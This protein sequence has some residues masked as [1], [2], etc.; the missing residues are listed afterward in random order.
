M[1]RIDIFICFDLKKSNMMAVPALTTT[2]PRFSGT[3]AMTS[4]VSHECGLLTG[5]KRLQDLQN[6]VSLSLGLIGSHI[7]QTPDPEGKTAGRVA[8]LTVCAETLCTQSVVPG[9]A[10]CVIVCERFPCCLQKRKL[11]RHVSWRFPPL[12]LKLACV[13]AYLCG[14]QALGNRGLFLLHHFP[15]LHSVHNNGPVPLLYPHKVR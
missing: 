7:P 15:P 14:P 3:W 13:Q 12:L 11:S 1:Y 2:M 9:V 6:N 5:A 10:D 8:T 4:N